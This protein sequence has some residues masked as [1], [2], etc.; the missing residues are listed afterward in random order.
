M[1]EP[2]QRSPLHEHHLRAGARMVPF[3]GWAMPLQ[4]PAGILKE[5]RA[6]R[7]VAGLFDVSHMARFRV[8]GPGALAFC[9]HVIT[10]NVEKL[11]PGRLLYTAVCN[12]RGGVLDDVTVYRFEDGALLVVN[13]SNR[14][15][16]WSWLERERESWTGE[17][18]EL[19]DAS[20]RLA[21]VAFQGPRAQEILLNETSIDLDAVGYYHYTVGTL[22]G[23]ENVLISRNGYTGE[24]GFE[25]YL[26]AEQAGEAWDR[27]LERGAGAGVLPAGLGSRDI[28]RLEMAYCLY[29]NELSEDVTPLQAGLGWTVRWKKKA[30]FIGRDA[31]VREKEAGPERVLAGFVVEGRRLARGGEEIR[32]GG[33]AVGRVTSGGFSPSLD[34]GIGMGLIEPVYAKPETNLTLDVRGTEVQARVVE[35]PFYTQAS[36][37]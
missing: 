1:A 30:G 23:F 18:F 2:L 34:Q 4:Y 25:I 37:R 36:H 19:E 6:V 7:E 5:H 32:T 11:E 33:R 14:S 9:N 35:R 22:F 27:L 26:A 28:L 20:A 8:R 3:A 10:N 31:L 16:I 12:E 17:P 21:Q 15:K 24:D 29:G 13:A